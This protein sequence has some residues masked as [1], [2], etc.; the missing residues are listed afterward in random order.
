MLPREAVGLNSLLVDLL[1]SIAVLSCLQAPAESA[2]FSCPANLQADRLLDRWHALLAFT[3]VARI[4][5]QLRTEKW[6]E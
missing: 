4:L 2:H 6:I 5:F 3:E 1:S